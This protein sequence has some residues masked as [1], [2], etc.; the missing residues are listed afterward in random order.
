MTQPPPAVQSSAGQ[1]RI[2]PRR[3]LRARQIMRL[4]FRGGGSPFESREQ[5]HAD[6]NCIIMV[7]ELAWFCFLESCDEGIPRLS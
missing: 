5:P 1:D 7:R 2:I 4:I 6:S 3:R